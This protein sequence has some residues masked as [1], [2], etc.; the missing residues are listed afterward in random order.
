MEVVEVDGEEAAALVAATERV[1]NDGN[2]AGLANRVSSGG[3]GADV[4]LGEPRGDTGRDV[5]G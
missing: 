4:G 1:E 5:E 2:G 3:R